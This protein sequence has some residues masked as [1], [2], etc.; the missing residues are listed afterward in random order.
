MSE[1]E[2]M[3]EAFNGWAEENSI[4]THPD[5]REEWFNCFKCGWRAAVE[6]G[7][8]AYKQEEE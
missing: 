4:G 2:A 1:Y 3:V 8:S 5:D 6:F 7:N